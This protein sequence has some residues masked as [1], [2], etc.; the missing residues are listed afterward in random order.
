MKVYTFS[1]N[2]A[3]S[4]SAPFV[5]IE[6]I[7]YDEQQTPIGLTAQV[8]S[9]SDA[10]AMPLTLLRRI[11]A[12]Y[13]ETRL[14]RGISGILQPVDM[15]LVA[16]R[17]ANLTFYRTVLAIHGDEAIIGRDILNDLTVTLNGP[18]TMTEI[19]VENSS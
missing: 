4:P 14:M 7:D 12:R 19:L 2:T 17:L 5:E 9:G 8:D 13:E 16:I 3:Y 15:Y 1:Y 6:L 18:A 10:S 11:K